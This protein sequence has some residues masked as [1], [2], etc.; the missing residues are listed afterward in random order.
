MS[1]QNKY[2]HFSFL[3]VWL[4]I[5]L[6]LSAFILGYQFKNF[7][8]TGVI[9]VKGLAEAE[10]KATLGTWQVTISAR[11][12]TYN[13]AMQNNQQ[14]L[15]IAMDFLNKQGFATEDYQIANL[16]VDEYREYYV[17]E[18]GKDRSRQNGFSATRSINIS[19][20]NL[21]KLQ[22]ALVAIQLLRA[23]N[24]N[25]DFDR[26][27]YYLEN[28]EK[29]KRELIAKATQDAYIRAEE[30]AKT[31]NVKVGVLKSASQGSFDIQSSTPSSEDNSDYGGSYD[32]STID[33]KVR[34]VVT[35]QY[36]IN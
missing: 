34:L 6:I 26:P 25:I 22:N 17:D 3:G 36:T 11:G 29:I 24:Q 9:T 16:S 20:K 2:R 32:T 21:T 5:G 30:F 13:E 7:Q 28:L 12:Q 14:N 1:K 27:N 4:A 19:S 8:Q 15:N 10:Y 23:E 35:I 18:H 33:K 31:S